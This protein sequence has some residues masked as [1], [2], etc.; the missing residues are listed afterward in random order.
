LPEPAGWDDDDRP[1]ERFG[2]LR[3]DCA[4]HRGPHLRAL[5]LVALVL[6]FLAICCP[7]LS[8]LALLPA[9]GLGLTA[10]V[11]AGRD[12]RAMEEGRMD[13]GGLR[14]TIRAG[15]DG[16]AGALMALI[17]LFIVICFF[18]FFLGR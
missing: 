11:L 5:G 2:A 7:P 9:V 14:A 1:W 13:S 10:S 6:G 15:E 12:L 4:P 16:R 8:L 3:R 17:G 18:L